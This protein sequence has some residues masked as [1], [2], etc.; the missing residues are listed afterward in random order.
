[1]PCT[2]ELG[3]SYLKKL[4]LIWPVEYAK[5]SAKYYLLIAIL[6]VKSLQVVHLHS[7]QLWKLSPEYS[8]KKRR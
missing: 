1:M 6:G 2:Q 5:V 4:L 8:D 3:A 7:P